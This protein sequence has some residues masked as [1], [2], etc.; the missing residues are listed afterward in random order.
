M[1]TC[2]ELKTEIKRLK[3]ARKNTTSKYLK[4]DYSKAI[5]RK[6]KELKIYY[7]YQRRKTS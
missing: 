5:K 3:E 1:T 4:T 7:F 2:E 6:E